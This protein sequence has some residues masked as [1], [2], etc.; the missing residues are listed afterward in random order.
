MP[1]LAAVGGRRPGTRVVG[2]LGY[3]A[4][5]AGRAAVAARVGGRV[6]PDSATH[7]ASV[8]AFA[9]LNAVSWRRRLRGAATWKGRPLP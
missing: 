4:A 9:A 5:V 1:P 2:A 6:W 3:A 8:L 7:P